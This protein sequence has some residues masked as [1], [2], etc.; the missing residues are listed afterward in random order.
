MYNGM[1]QIKKNSVFTATKPKVIQNIGTA[2]VVK[3]NYGRSTR[4]LRKVFSHLNIS[5]TDMLTFI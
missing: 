3:P 1:D 5:R 2:T 4:A